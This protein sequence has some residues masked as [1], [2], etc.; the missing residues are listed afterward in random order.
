MAS[1][2]GG[3]DPLLLLEAARQAV[4]RAPFAAGAQANLAMILIIIRRADLALVAG[5]NAILLSPATGAFYRTLGHAFLTQGERHMAARALRR[6]IRVTP[7]DANAYLSL[8]DAGFDRAQPQPAVAVAAADSAHAIGCCRQAILLKPDHTVA[9]NTLGTLLRTAGHATAART[10]F[11]HAATL[12]PDFPEARNNL[13]VASAECDDPEISVRACRQAIVLRPNY[14]DAYN[15]LGTAWHVMG[16]FA[17]AARAFRH[18]IALQPDN[19]DPH[20]N[21]GAILCA[22]GR[23]D[24]AIASYDRALARQSNNPLFHLNHATAL[25][26]RGDFPA[27]WA[28]YDTARQ[29][30]ATPLPVSQ[31]KWA[32]EPLSGRTLLLHAEQ[33]FGDILQF[34]RYVPILARQ[35]ARIVLRVRAPLVRLLR[36]LAGVAV[37]GSL[38]DPM[39]PFD[40]HLPLVSLPPLLGTTLDTIPADVPY[41]WPVPGEITAWRQRLAALPGRKIGLVWAGDPRAYHREAHQLD[42]RRS[43]PLALFA[44]LGAIPG[45]SLISLQMGDA[46]A[47]AHPPPPGLILHDGMAQVSDFADSAALVSTLDLVIT[48]DTAAAHLAGA[49]GVPVWILSRYDGCWRWLQ[50][51]DDSP[52]YPTARLFRQQQPLDWGPVIDRVCQALIALNPPVAP[53]EPQQ[54]RA[55]PGSPAEIKPGR[56]TGGKTGTAKPGIPAG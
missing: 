49:L 50:G 28:E 21:L 47:Q 22:E 9:F 18:A 1:R 13:G 7:H 43:I 16:Q 51:R 2:P 29:A 53:G 30:L 25:L 24:A 12:S 37:V 5:R 45:I 56:I 15:N 3:R 26:H 10:A 31:P 6:A 39:P 32:G 19:P 27:G 48:V 52:W 8:A 35:G 42:R 55:L 46:A 4:R 54:N 20:N 34:C 44:P 11:R 17:A 14:A 40:Y 36:S 23:I 38:D 41:L 33:G